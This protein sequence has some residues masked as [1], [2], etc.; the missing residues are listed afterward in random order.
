MRALSVVVLVFLAALSGGPVS[1]ASKKLAKASPDALFTSANE[2]YRK[3]DLEGAIADYPRVLEGT[4]D[5]AVYT[6]RGLAK[7]DLGDAK[8]AL[9]DFDKALELDPNN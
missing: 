1:A 7:S 3:G 6:N 8:G 2:K 4:R 5:R 9:A